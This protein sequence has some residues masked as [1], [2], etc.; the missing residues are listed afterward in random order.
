M[1]THAAAVGSPFV[2]YTE[3]EWESYE[4]RLWHP[5]VVPGLLQTEQYARSLLGSGR[6]AGWP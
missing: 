3:I 5:Q 1:T 4:I 6:R 2:R